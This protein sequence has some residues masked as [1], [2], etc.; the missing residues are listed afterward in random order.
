MT[1]DQ[2]HYRGRYLGIRERDHWEFA[3]R[4]NASAV[5]ALVPVTD[6]QE[7]VLVEQFRIPVQAQVIELPAGLVGDLQDPE[8]SVLTAARRELEEETGYRAD[9]LTHLITCPSSAGL[10]DEMVIILLAEG[11]QQTGPGGGDASED[12]TVHRVPL[13]TASAWLAAAMQEGKQLDPKIYAALY[14]LERRARGQ[15]LLG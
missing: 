12:I 10:S 15:A 3:T 8:E 5:A 4:T 13:A 14:W 7:L 11:L 9:R 6:R 2:M 1:E